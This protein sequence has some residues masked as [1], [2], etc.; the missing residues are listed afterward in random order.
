[1]ASEHIND[2]T[3]LANTVR[4]KMAE[5]LVQQRGKYY[6]FGDVP[7]EFFVFDQA[8]NIDLAI[9]N[10]LEEERQCGGHNNRLHKRQIFMQYLEEI[11]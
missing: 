5:V 1:M 10:N 11:F 7:K 2:C 3:M 9:T 4:T 6:G 8:E